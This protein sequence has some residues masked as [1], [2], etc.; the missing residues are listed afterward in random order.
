MSKANQISKNRQ[1]DQNTCLYRTEAI[2]QVLI[3]TKKF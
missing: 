3:V 2:F 1:N